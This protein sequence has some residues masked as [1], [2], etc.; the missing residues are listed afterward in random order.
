[1]PDFLTIGT[2]GDRCGRTVPR[3]VLALAVAALLAGGL[4]SCGKRGDPY[5][6]SELPKAEDAKNPG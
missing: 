5:R 4:A 1:M 2:G 3:L 6:P